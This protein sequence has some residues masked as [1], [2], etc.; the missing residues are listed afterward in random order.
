MLNYAIVVYLS[1]VPLVL[2]LVMAFRYAMRLKVRWR[3]RQDFRKLLTANWELVP[4]KFE[5][6]FPKKE[7]FKDP[8]PAYRFENLRVPDRYK[9]DKGVEIP[10][11]VSDIVVEEQKLY[12]DGDV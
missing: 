9:A 6:F 11:N 12:R 3:E 1:F 8:E 10:P 4:Y 7:E 2:L 5:P